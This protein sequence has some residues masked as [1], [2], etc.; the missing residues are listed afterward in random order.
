MEAAI[1]LGEGTVQ[2]QGIHHVT[3]ITGDA[4]GNVDFY[5]RVLEARANAKSAIQGTT[6]PFTTTSTATTRA[7][8][9]TSRSSYLGRC[10]DGGRALFARVTK[11]RVACRDR[12][13]ARTAGRRGR[14]IRR[15]R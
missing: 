1:N 12:L 5:T 6:S 2:L 9:V 13:L 7:P 3:A 15:R 4:V 10:P 14:R 11:G 8:G